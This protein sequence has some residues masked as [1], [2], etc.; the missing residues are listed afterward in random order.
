MSP[1]EQF[2]F[3]QYNLLPSQILDSNH[4]KT[5]GPKVEVE[6]QYNNNNPLSPPPISY[7]TGIGLYLVDFYGNVDSY[8]LVHSRE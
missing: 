5:K 4:N 3:L 7:L 8:F 6:S 2:R 1:P